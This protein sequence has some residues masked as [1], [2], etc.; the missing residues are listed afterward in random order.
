MATKAPFTTQSF[1]SATAGTTVSCTI[2]LVAVTG[3]FVGTIKFKWN[4][5]NGVTHTVQESGADLAFTAAGERVLDFGVPVEVY[6]ECTAYTS[7]TAVVAMQYS[8]HSYGP[9]A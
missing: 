4:D 1:S 7:G 3:T 5:N 6:P 9:R 8:P 2:C